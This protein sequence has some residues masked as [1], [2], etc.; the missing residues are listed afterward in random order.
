[1]AFEKDEN[2]L[3]ALWSKTGAKG[4]YLTGEINGIKVV[5]FKQ[6]KRSEKSPDWRVLKSKPREVKD[7]KAP[8]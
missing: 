1:M 4:E 5:C 2:E 3:G 8:W 6:E 7:D